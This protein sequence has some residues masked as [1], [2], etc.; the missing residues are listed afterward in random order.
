MPIEA[1]MCAGFKAIPQAGAS[2]RDYW[3]DVR[4]S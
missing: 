4:S 3:T 1:G 2:L